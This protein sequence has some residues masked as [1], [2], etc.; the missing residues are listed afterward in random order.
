[1]VYALIVT[2][3]YSSVQSSWIRSLIGVTLAMTSTASA[4][5]CTLAP[6]I[7]L[8]HRLCTFSSSRMLLSEGQAHAGFVNS[9]CVQHYPWFLPLHWN[10]HQLESR[11]I[12]CSA[13]A[14][15]QSKCL[16]K[17]GATLTGGGIMF[18]VRLSFVLPL[19]LSSC[20]RVQH[21]RTSAACSTPSAV[22]YGVPHGIG[23]RANPIPS[24]HR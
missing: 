19:S 4:E 24:V 17:A 1:M 22:L 8:R 14:S 11:G 6:S 9:R 16:C 3:E 5:A 20:S 7:D 18:S 12:S 21:V 10:W 13:I 23:P 2:R 15:A